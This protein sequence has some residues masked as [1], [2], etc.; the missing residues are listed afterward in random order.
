MPS[1]SRAFE[2]IENLAYQEDFD[3]QSPSTRIRISSS[4]MQDNR[5][6]RSQTLSSW[7]R[8]IHM[9]TQMPLSPSLLVISDDPNGPGGNENDRPGSAITPPL[10]PTRKRPLP[11]WL[12]RSL[13]QSHH[14]PYSLWP[15]M[16]QREITPLP[17]QHSAR[18][19]SCNTSTISPRMSSVSN[20]PW[21]RR[22]TSSMPSKFV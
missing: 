18:F 22:S 14:S 20:N 17:S 8:S 9:P 10:T 4:T 16:H 3:Q 21:Q 6:G 1:T 12:R 11:S 5:T 13:A 2:G 19:R 15:S 7:N